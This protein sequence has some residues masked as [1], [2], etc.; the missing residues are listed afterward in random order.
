MIKKYVLIVVVVWLLLALLYGSA[1]ANYYSFQTKDKVT[2]EV[3]MVSG[4][5]AIYTCA[6]ERYCY[7]KALEYEARGAEQ[8]CASLIM[9]RNDKVIWWRQY[10]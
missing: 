4:V 2:M 8:Y 1:Q 7:T 3:T 9:K 6:S 10:Q 5:K